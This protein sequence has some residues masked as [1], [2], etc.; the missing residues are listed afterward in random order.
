MLLSGL[1][2]LCLRLCGD[3]VPRLRLNP[4]FASALAKAVRGQPTVTYG[5]GGRSKDKL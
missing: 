4:T 3:L 5:I 2:Q 1:A